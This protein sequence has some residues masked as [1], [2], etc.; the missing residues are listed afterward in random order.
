MQ[1]GGKPYFFTGFN[2]YYL[3]SYGPWEAGRVAEI[4]AVFRYYLLLQAGMMAWAEY[5]M[6]H[7]SVW[8]TA[9][10][11]LRHVFLQ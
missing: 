2:N 8:S 7:G 10:F 3:P 9:V 6:L 11:L 4:D 1:A 5:Q